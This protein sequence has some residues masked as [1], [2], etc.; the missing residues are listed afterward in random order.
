MRFHPIKNLSMKQRQSSNNNSGYEHTLK[1]E[2]VKPNSESKAK[3]RLRN[4]TWFH[5]PYSKHMATNV[6]K[7]FLSIVK[8]CFK[9]NHPLHKTFNKNTLQISYSCML[10]LE[11]KITSHNKAI[12][13]NPSRTNND[14]INQCNCIGTSLNA[15][16]MAIA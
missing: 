13:A 16:L 14:E 9:Q 2:N 10:N 5:P 11:A 4:I 12:L 6:G 7:N 1:Y 15:L 8:D 3:N